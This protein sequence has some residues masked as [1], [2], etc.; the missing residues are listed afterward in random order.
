MG[1]NAWGVGGGNFAIGTTS[2]SQ[3]LTIT[4]TGVVNIPG[5]LRVGNVPVAT[6][7]QYAA[8]FKYNGTSLEY[9]QSHGAVNVTTSMLSRISL[10]NYRI[11]IPQATVDNA[12]VIATSNTIGNC[13]VSGDVINGTEIALTGIQNAGAN[14][15]AIS[16]MTIP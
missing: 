10:G 3:C 14:D 4:P 8:R 1:H 12:C 2:Q 13:V 15:I 7:P 6:K 9:L 11:A 5:S 16:F